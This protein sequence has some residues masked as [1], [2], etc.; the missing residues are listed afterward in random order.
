MHLHFSVEEVE[1]REYEVLWFLHHHGTDRQQTRI[2]GSPLPLQSVP[3]A[4]ATPLPASLPNLDSGLFLQVCVCVR[5][6][7]TD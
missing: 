1:E 7:Q 2:C 4:L 3:F 6:R 5:E